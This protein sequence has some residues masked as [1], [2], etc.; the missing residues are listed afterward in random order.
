MKRSKWQSFQA[1]NRRLCQEN[2][3]LKQ[4]VAQLESQVAQWVARVAQLESQVA[5]QETHI[6]QLTTQLEASQRQAKR[7]AAPFSKGPPKAHPKKRPGAGMG[8]RLTTNRRLPKRSM[9]FY[10]TEIPCRVIYRQFHIHIG[11]CEECGQRVQGRHDLQTSD[12]LGAGTSQL[13]LNLQAAIAFLNK[14]CGLFH[15]KIVQFFRELVTVKTRS[16]FRA[17]ASAARHPLCG[18]PPR[19]ANDSAKE[20][21][22]NHITARLEEDLELRPHENAG[23]ARLIVRTV[24]VGRDMVEPGG[25]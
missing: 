5:Q 23:L 19:Q 16:C 7:Q 11:C 24:L 6:A 4:R 13:G 25:I 15:G 14:R 8:S 21:Q 10:Q 18:P 17:A 9:S 3:S 2:R 20:S 22:F 12:A 1:E